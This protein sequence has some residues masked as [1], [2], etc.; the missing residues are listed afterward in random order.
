MK[1]IITLTGILFLIV[2][3]TSCYGS[4][5]FAPHKEYSKDL[6]HSFDFEV[7][8]VN[9]LV[10]FVTNIA[11]KYG[12]DF[13][14][15]GVVLYFKDKAQIENQSGEIKLIYYKRVE[16]WSQVTMIVFSC[17]I[18]NKKI[19]KMDYQQAHSKKIDNRY[20]TYNG[21]EYFLK[22]PISDMFSKIKEK[23][24][25]NNCDSI[26]FHFSW[27]RISVKINDAWEELDI[28]E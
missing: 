7:L 20:D 13:E 15:N 12:K 19:Y 21:N 26:E 22:L 6:D 1:K 23:T 17:D 2:F 5:D 16:K 25:L 24:D 18:Q 3:L 28:L 10:P 11:S 8:C 27:D 4:E 9:D 14:I